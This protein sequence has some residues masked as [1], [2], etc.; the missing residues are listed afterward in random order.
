MPAGNPG[1]VFIRLP[2][3]AI[4]SWITLTPATRGAVNAEGSYVF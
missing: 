1:I 3:D 2:P 4:L